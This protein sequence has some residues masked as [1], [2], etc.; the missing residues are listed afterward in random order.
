TDQCPHS[1]RQRLRCCRAANFSMMAEGARQ[2]QP[3]RGGCPGSDARSA[4]AVAQTAVERPRPPAPTVG[5]AMPHL[6]AGAVAIPVSVV[7]AGPEVVMMAMPVMEVAPVV[8]TKV[9]VPVVVT[10]VAVP[11]V[12]V[13]AMAS[14]AAD[15][16]DHRSSVRGVRGLG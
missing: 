12:P 2:L 14:A 5:A 4:T 1:A 16:L 8:V 13:A 10:E 7:E 11:A 6:R 3:L 9:P 15:L